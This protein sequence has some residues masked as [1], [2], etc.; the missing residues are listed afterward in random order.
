MHEKTWYQYS[1]CSIWESLLGYINSLYLRSE[2]NQHKENIY[3]ERE[4][5]KKEKEST[6]W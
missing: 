3:I 4:R 5:M 2:F 6:I 1:I